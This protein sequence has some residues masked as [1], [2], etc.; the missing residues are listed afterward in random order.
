MDNDLQC[1]VDGLA[2]GEGVLMNRD[3]IIQ[4]AREAGFGWDDKYH[5]YVGSRQMEK[6]AALVA[7][8]EREACAVLA[9]NGLLG[10]TI[11]QAIR[12]RGDKS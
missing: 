2:D 3:D 10:I 9:E 7:A 4:M 5:W 1:G 8:Q 12:A 11:A 6:F